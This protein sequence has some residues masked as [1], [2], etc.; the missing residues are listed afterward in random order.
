LFVAPV[1]YA[2]HCVFAGLSF[3]LMDILG[4]KA[5][6]TFSG[7]LIDLIMFWEKDTH[8]EYIIPVGLAFAVIYYF[9][10]RFAIKIW[11]LKTPGREDDEENSGVEVSENGNLAQQVLEALGGKD[12]LANLDACIT[13][14]R[15]SVNDVG[16]V[17]KNRLKQLGASGVLEMGNHL[18]VIFGPKSDLIKEQMKR[19]MMGQQP[20]VKLDPEDVT[21]ADENQSD[22]LTVDFSH[23]A[24]PMSGKLL[25]IHEVPDEVFSQK[26]MGDGFAIEPSEGVVLSPVDGTVVNLFP[27]KHAIGIKS[28]EGQEILIHVGIDTV[29]LDGKGF[30]TFVS[31]GDKVTKG[32]KLLNVDLDFIA[33]EAKS[34]ITPVVFTNWSGGTIQVEKKEVKAGD[35]KFIQ[36]K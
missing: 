22:T 18:Q 35:E 33:K 29:K 13:R 19:I 9:G 6:Q 17:D 11:D 8:P 10:F 31:E 34:T 24:A 23:F 16:K 36:A 1:L 4:V 25:P 2:V 20:T 7:G 27:T 15:I 28:D 26:M 32:Q 14:L 3:M 21:H 5:G 30:E 12:N